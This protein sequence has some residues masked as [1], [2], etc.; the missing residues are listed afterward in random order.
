[1]DRLN[2]FN[3]FNIHINRY[4]I[5]CNKAACFNGFAPFQVIIETVNS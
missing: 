1:M 3:Q 2:L 4:D 5:A